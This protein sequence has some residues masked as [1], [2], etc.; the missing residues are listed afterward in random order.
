MTDREQSNGR[1]AKSGQFVQGFT[2]NPNGRPKGSRNKLGEQFL[3]DLHAEWERSGATA[4]KAMAETDPSGFVRVVSQVLPRELDATLTVD[5]EAFQ[6]A[7][8]FLQAYR[9]AR[10]FIQA[11]NEPP[12]LEL[13]ADAGA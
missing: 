5:L 2:G 1:D 12:L 6:R 8:T 10:D 4:L 9:L 7:E 3:S 11:E 13:E